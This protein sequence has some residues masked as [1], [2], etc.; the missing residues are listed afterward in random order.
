MKEYTEQQQNDITWL[1]GLLQ[2]GDKVY[3]I[4]RR[5]SQS[6][7]MRVIDLYIIKDSKPI[8]ISRETARLLGYTEDKKDYGLRVSGCGMDMIFHLVYSLANVLF[9]NGY[10]LKHEQL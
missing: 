4:V 3:G 6:G 8:N 7:M 10:S 5:V 1:K 2:P 9:Q